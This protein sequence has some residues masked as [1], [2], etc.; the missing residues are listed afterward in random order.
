MHAILRRQD[1]DY[2]DPLEL[3]NDSAL[4]VPGLVDAVRRGNVLIANAL[5]SN[6]LE[7]SALLGYLPRLSERLLGEPLRMPSVATW[8]CGEPAAL[9]EVVKNLHRLVIKARF[10]SFG[11][12]R[13][14][15]RTSTSAAGSA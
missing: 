1:D 12:S 7:S 9:E 4:G 8:W 6:L 3:R 11:A 14:S 13:S 15:A 10:R 5:G 2:C